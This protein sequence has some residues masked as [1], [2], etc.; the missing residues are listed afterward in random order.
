MTLDYQPQSKT[1]L[2]ERIRQLIEDNTSKRISPAKSRETLERIIASMRVEVE[3]VSGGGS[4]VPAYSA[5]EVVTFGALRTYNGQYWGVTDAVRANS[6]APTQNINSGWF[7]WSGNDHWL[8]RLNG[9]QLFVH[10]GDMGFWAEGEVVELW[11]YV[12]NA[13]NWNFASRAPFMSATWI[14]VNKD[15]TD[16]IYPDANG[17]LRAATM[18]D[19]GRIALEHSNIRIGEQYTSPGHAGVVNWQRLTSITGL[20]FTYRGTFAFLSQIYAIANPAEDD[21]A[22]SRSGQRWYR[23]G[24]AIW[25]QVNGPPGYPYIGNQGTKASAT[26]AV[27]RRDNAVGVIAEFDFDVWQ[28]VAPFVQLAEDQIRFRWG[29]LAEI[30]T[31]F[32]RKI[33]RFP[34]VEVSSIPA[35]F[36][37]NII[38]LSHDYTEGIKDDIAVTP[39]AGTEIGWGFE[40]G[41]IE[42]QVGMAPDRG[43]LEQLSGSGTAA[44]YGYQVYASFNKHWMD[45]ADKVEIDG[46]EYSIGP[47]YNYDAAWYRE[48]IGVPHTLSAA[49]TSFNVKLL[50]GNWYYTDGTITR[51]KAGLYQWVVDVYKRIADDGALRHVDGSGGPTSLPTEA[52]EVW[53][54]DEAQVWVGGDRIRVSTGPQITYS[55]F[56]GNDYWKGID[57]DPALL[58]DGEFTWIPHLSSATGLVLLRQ[59]R[60][61]NVGLHNWRDVWVYILTIAGQNT[62]AHRA[63]RDATFLGGFDDTDETAHAISL[64]DDIDTGSFYFVWSGRGLFHVE[65]YIVGVTHY[66]DGF[67]WYGPLISSGEVLQLIAR[68]VV[69]SDANGQLRDPTEAD[70][71]QVIGIRPTGIYFPDKVE[72]HTTSPTGSW[73]AIGGTLTAQSAIVPGFLGFHT[74]H[75]LTSLPNPAVD[76]NFIGDLVEQQFYEIYTPTGA[77]YHAWRRR[78]NP[79]NFVGWFASRSLFL[80]TPGVGVGSWGWSGV[81]G[82]QLVTFLAGVH[83]HTEYVWRRSDQS[84]ITLDS[85]NQLVGGASVI[86]DKIATITFNVNGDVTV[87][88]SNELTAATIGG[89]ATPQNWVIE[90]GVPDHFVT[91]GAAG[92]SRLGIPN[93]R[94]SNEIFGFIARLYRYRLYGRLNAVHSAGA[95]SL[96]FQLESYE[97][98]VV[99]TKMQLEDEI[100][101]VTSVPAD[102]ASGV[103]ARSFGVSR[104]VDGTVAASHV[105]FTEIT[106]LIN[107][108]VLYDE[109]DFD[110]GVSSIFNQG[111]EASNISDLKT[112]VNSAIQ[113]RYV[114]SELVAQNYIA[115]FGRRGDV[116]SR[117][118]VEIYFRV[119]PEVSSGLTSQEQS[120]VPTTFA[121][122]I[123]E[124]RYQA[125]FSEP[126]P[127][128]P[129]WWDV[130]TGII[131]SAFPNWYTSKEAAELASPG[132]PVWIASGGIYI[133][134]SGTQILIPWTVVQEFGLRFST[135]A[136]NWH[137]IKT[138]DDIF[139]RFRFQDGSYSPAIRVGDTSDWVQIYSDAVYVSSGSTDGTASDRV[140]AQSIFMDAFQ[141]VRIIYTPFG[142]WAVDG[143]PYP[144]GLRSGYCIATST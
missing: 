7:R 48:I 6:N 107:D 91:V 29:Q 64:R 118:R 137:P 95:S 18:T 70:I 67:F 4:A 105:G 59:K 55:P 72:Y 23:R 53:V 116:R 61:E 127:P 50:N 98:I 114:A 122:K 32:E 103:A 141:E 76:G 90:S 77:N 79:A 125:S 1:D 136:S 16:V 132:H 81:R 131:N 30:K 106:G 9:L 101:E 123:T 33:P 49:I 113:V 20:T 35:T 68:R 140:F 34:I 56:S 40:S 71:G 37:G 10:T 54:N 2:V 143:S 62:A 139:L 15:D 74:D 39:G 73:R 17:N 43:P 80:H 97:P 42:Q 135:D 128:G 27:I 117:T 120:V 115:L 52:G 96:I 108:I 69:G 142:G 138:E 21:Y 65:S 28:V 94:P 63:L 84:K 78:D 60:G 3:P 82:E 38:S 102:N 124:V 26:N 83:G 99:G 19:I 92:Q 46:N 121:R 109:T 44:A 133:T 129:I 112:G 93:L 87:V 24:A 12:G 41:A 100:V 66:H 45:A 13:Q 58:A 25:E 57:Y 36:Q 111:A 5:D 86:G 47:V 22:F 8:G 14:Q 75:S 89:G 51:H 11:I 119:I 110:W 144:D 104:G 85:N 88:A 126:Q 130:S 134:T 31:L